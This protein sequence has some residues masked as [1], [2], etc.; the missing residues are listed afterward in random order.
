LRA[1]FFCL[2][3]CQFRFWMVWLNVGHI[4]M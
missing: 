1:M 3:G 4:C 2:H